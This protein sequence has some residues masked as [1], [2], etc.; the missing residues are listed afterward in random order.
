MFYMG[1]PQL[2]HR[3]TL[4]L[5]TTYSSCDECITH[6][7]VSGCLNLAYFWFEQVPQHDIVAG[8]LF[9]V[10]LILNHRQYLILYD[11]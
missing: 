10:G 3:V 5:I 4:S 2:A 8:K 1:Y 7:V 9:A 11:I 6:S